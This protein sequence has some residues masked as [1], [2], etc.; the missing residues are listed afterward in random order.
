METNDRSFIVFSQL[1]NSQKLHNSGLD[2]LKAEVVF[3]KLLLAHKRVQ[4]FWIIDAPRQ[5]RHRLQVVHRVMILLTSRSY[6]LN[7]LDLL[8]TDFF[9]FFTHLQRLY[10]AFQF[11]NLV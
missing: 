7:L 2:R 10:L 6:L 9:R 4:V 1:S 8:P 3:V 5:V 11:F